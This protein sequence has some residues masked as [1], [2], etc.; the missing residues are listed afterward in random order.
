M[1]NSHN[2]IIR[3]YLK[4]YLVVISLVVS[5]SNTTSNLVWQQLAM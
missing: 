5:Q 4:K 2:N 3:Y 1:H